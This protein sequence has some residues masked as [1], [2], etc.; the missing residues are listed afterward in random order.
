MVLSD[1]G[2]VY[3]RPIRPDDAER[4]VAFHG[5]QSAESIYYRFFS[6][7]P[8]LSERDVTRFTTVDYTTRLALVALL[9]EDLI[10]VA[11]YDSVLADAA[12]TEEGSASVRGAEVAF[13]IDDR[14]HGRGLATLLLEFLA[15]AA[16]EAGIDGFIASVLPDNRGMINVFRRAGFEVATEFRDGVVEVRL[17]IRP[18]PEGQIHIEDR[19]RR[20]EAA[21]VARVLTPA[22]IAVIGAGRRPGSLGHQVLGQLLAGGFNGAVYPVNRHTTHVHGV[23][24]YPTVGAIPDEI[25]LA[26]VAVPP[27][28][29]HAV[30]ADCAKKRVDALVVLTDTVTPGAGPD[31]GPDTDPN[32]GELVR[33]ARLHGMRLIGPASIGVLNHAPDVR[34][35]ATFAPVVPAP[36]RVAVSTQSGS[37][38]NAILA[39]AAETG[40]GVSAFVNLGDKADVSA[41]DL[42]QYWGDD[43]TTDVIA[44]YLE[45]FGNPSKFFRIARRLGRTKPVVVM[46]TASLD[47]GAAPTWP[48]EATYSSLMTQAGILETDSLAELF[49]LARFLVAQPLPQGRRVVV[50]ANSAG[51]AALGMQTAR[52]AG[53]QA[54]AR[55]VTGDVAAFAAAVAAAVSAPPPTEPATEGAGYDAVLVVFAPTLGQDAAAAAA[56]VDTAVAADRPPLSLDLPIGMSQGQRPVLASYF[57]EGRFDT[58]SQR[59]DLPRYRF[60]EEACRVLAHAARYGQWRNQPQG[61][62]ARFEQ[63]DLDRIGSVV[64]RVVGA[65]PPGG[66]QLLALADALVLLRAAGLDPVPQVEADGLDQV[67]AAAGQ[68]GY[69]VALKAVRRARLARSAAT[70]L[71]L[72]LHDE[73]ELRAAYRTMQDGLGAGLDIPLGTV[74]V[75]VMAEAGLDAQLLGHQDNRLGPLVAL[76]R[77]G[78]QGSDPHELAVR[79]VPLTTVDIARL[80][81]A[82]PLASL[83]ARLEQA[84]TAGSNAGLV[85]LEEVLGRLSSLMEQVP[86]L[87]EVRLDPVLVSPSGLAI[88]DVWVHVAPVPLAPYPAVRRL[89]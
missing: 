2:T 75:Q 71:A 66:S 49:G 32:P 46:R 22:T 60:P 79:L 62:V 64:G 34:L 23:R 82:S 25:D 61:P 88:T 55:V 39:Y 59:G 14:H 20:A 36:G 28:Q 87:A 10:G 78:A 51:T 31:T 38:G 47:R 67:V 69:P 70:G 24:A 72:G 4:L 57:G 1:G 45:S 44:L 8:R 68:L 84:N 3:V 86:E 80:V 21:S 54:Q 83:V 43:D 76:G 7:R 37:M 35:A 19:G 89:R 18:T 13:F 9:G 29:L 58:V 48:G 5:R 17:G 85:A 33:I 56:A 16:S 81:Q 15:V 41:N 42:L 40:L 6:P 53:L 73:T 26:I 52:Q 74:V 77:G 11:R 65:V 50:L 63:L 27:D 30:I 12:S